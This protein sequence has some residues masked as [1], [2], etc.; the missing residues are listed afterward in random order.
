MKKTLLSAAIALLCGNAALAQD[1]TY[2][3]T[4]AVVNRVAQFQFN[5]DYKYF[6][7]AMGDNTKK[8][9]IKDDAKQYQY[10]GVDDYNCGFDWWTAA[11]TK[12]LSAG[13]NSFG[14]KDSY[15]YYQA[16]KT[17]YMG[18]GYRIFDVTNAENP[19]D[20]KPAVIDLSSIPA[21]YKLH[22]SLKCDNDAQVMIKFMDGYKG[23]DPE[24][25]DADEAHTAVL[26][27]ADEAW[28]DTE[29]VCNFNR[30]GD[31]QNIDI[32]LSVLKDEY[33]YD[34]QKYGK[35][36]DQNMMTVEVNG[37]G[38]KIAW[39]AVFFYGPQSSITGIKDIQ[40]E[41]VSAP[42]QVYTLD[43]KVISKEAAAAQKGIY[44]VRQG[45]KSK[46]VVID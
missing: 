8:T 28:D 36:T 12:T 33:G 19:E 9:Y 31:F 24:Y 20:E 40:K 3:F 45:N 15:M 6:A 41:N 42:L 18:F 26:L 23:D 16:K 2:Q 37:A 39:D 25:P 13:S 17:D 35:L 46:K 43:G 10:I 21:D 22:L 14:I 4:P 29:P 11:N 32:P 38:A 30:N 7:I 44:I 1:Y 34:L 27:F 5:D